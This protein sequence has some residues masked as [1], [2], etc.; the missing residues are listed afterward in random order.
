MI[1]LTLFEYELWYGRDFFSDLFLRV[2]IK[3]YVCIKAIYKK[4]IFE[5]MKKYTYITKSFERDAR[6]S[7]TFIGTEREFLTGWDNISYG[8][9]GIQNT[10]SES[11]GIALLEKLL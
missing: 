1:A 9:Y 3:M 2:A 11:T 8:L 5:V 10:I 6:P 4:L 7:R